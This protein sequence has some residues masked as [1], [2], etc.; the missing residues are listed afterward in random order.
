MAVSFT[1]WVK[2]H[3]AVM[4]FDYSDVPPFV[5]AHDTIGLWILARRMRKVFLSSDALGLL[6]DF[7]R[8]WRD[9]AVAWTNAH[10]KIAGHPPRQHDGAPYPLF[11]A[12]LLSLV[13]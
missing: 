1:D 10:E 6:A 5:L 3:L 9:F 13:F 11:I 2:P 7:F 12:P 4:P 8:A